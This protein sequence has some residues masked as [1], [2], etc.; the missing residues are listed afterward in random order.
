MQKLLAAI[1]DG[2]TIHVCDSECLNGFSIVFY[3]IFNTITKA[4]FLAVKLL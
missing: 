2:I 4:Y 3:T 1:N